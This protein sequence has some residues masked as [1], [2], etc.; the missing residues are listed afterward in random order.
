MSNHE[1]KRVLG[2]LGARELTAAELES[3]HGGFH[4]FVCTI[5]LPNGARDGDACQA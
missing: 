2:R 3:V 4:T 5:S 1:D